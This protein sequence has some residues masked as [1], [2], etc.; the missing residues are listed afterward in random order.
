MKKLH[1]ALQVSH[2]EAEE[3][4]GDAAAHEDAAADFLDELDQIRLDKASLE[5]QMQETKVSSGL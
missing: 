1:E 5:A 3:A 2:Q 4:R